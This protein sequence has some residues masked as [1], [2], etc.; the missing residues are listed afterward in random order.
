M[1]AILVYVY[2]SMVLYLTY[3]YVHIYMYICMYGR[4]FHHLWNK[5]KKLNA[6]IKVK[7]N[8]QI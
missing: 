6:K 2:L 4:I 5:K 8:E 1:T 3:M 7:Y